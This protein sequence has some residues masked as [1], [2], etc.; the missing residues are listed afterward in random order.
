MEREGV[1]E[2]GTLERWD[3]NKETMQDFEAQA[4]KFRFDAQKWALAKKLEI[5]SK[6]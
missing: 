3:G 4:R 6:V 2:K 5:E 1:P